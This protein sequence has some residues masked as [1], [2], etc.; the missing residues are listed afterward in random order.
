MWNIYLSERE[1][2]TRY[3]QALRF[4]E[5]HRLVRRAKQGQHR[6]LVSQA[7]WLSW[8]VGVLLVRFGQ[9]LQGHSRPQVVELEPPIN[10]S[11]YPGRGEIIL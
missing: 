11:A 10:G 1:A 4:A 5:N 2:S 6:G 8:R 3:N 9:W 7:K